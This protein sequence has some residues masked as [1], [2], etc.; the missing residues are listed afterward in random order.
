MKFTVKELGFTMVDQANA[1][2]IVSDSSSLSAR[3]LS[4]KSYVGIGLSALT[5]VKNSGLLLGYHFVSTRNG[6]EGLVKAEITDH[7]LTSGYKADEL[8]YLTSG[9]WITSVPAGTEV[10]A[11]IRNHDDFFVAGWWPGHEKAKGQILAFTHTTNQTT[12][13]LFANELAFR[14]HTHYSNRFIANS[15]FDSVQTRN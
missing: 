8:L 9:A 7:V 6:H 15:I 1:D 11:S 10:L 14:A 13:T 2:V 4:G 5:A 12:F 3:T